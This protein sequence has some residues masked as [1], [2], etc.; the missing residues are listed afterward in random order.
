MLQVAVLLLALFGC[1]ITRWTIRTFTYW[2]DKGV[3][4]LSF[5]EYMR[6]AYDIFTKPLY[7]VVQRNYERHGRVYGTYQGFVPTLVVGDPNLLRD[8]CVRDF[9]SFADRSE[10]KI[11]GNDIWDRMV[12]NSTGNEWTSSR[13]TVTPSFTSSKLKGFV[14]KVLKVAEGVCSR[15]LEKGRDGGATEIQDT[16]SESAMDVMTSLVFSIDV[17]THDNPNHPVV[18]SCNGLFGGQGGWKLVM[19]YA[20]IDEIASQC[21][22]CIVAGT[23]AVK[24]TLTCAVYN[25]AMHPQYQERLI[26]EV[27]DTLK[28]TDVTYDALKAMPFLEAVIYETLRMYTPDSFLTRV[29]TKETVVSGIRLKPGMGI[30]FPLRGVH[31]DSEFFPDPYLFNPERFLP[32]N[33]PNMIPYTFLA[34]GEGPRNCVG[35]RMATV[36]IKAML[37]TIYRVMKF[38]RCSET[39]DQLKFVPRSLLL[40]FQEPIKVQIIPRSPKK[41]Q[42]AAANDKPQ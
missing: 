16:F 10:D 19:L 20:E 23:D 38:E 29:C 14:S 2:N 11:T 8:I 42:R 41:A 31:Y 35:T 36:V 5:M 37:A 33:K 3:P 4:H 25:L 21:M 30:E 6:T 32:E 17:N 39:P 12:L 24:H 15:L 34:F 26:Q 1:F 7:E 22:L 18:D 40:E 27:D 28:E 9:K 13:S